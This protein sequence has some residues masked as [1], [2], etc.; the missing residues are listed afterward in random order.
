[1][2]TAAFAETIQYNS[3]VSEVGAASP[4]GQGE[5]DRGRER[6]ILR[7][8]RCKSRSHEVEAG[9]VMSG[10]DIPPNGVQTSKGTLLP[11]QMPSAKA[12]LGMNKTAAIQAAKLCQSATNMSRTPT[13]APVNA[14]SKPPAVQ[15]AGSW[16]VRARSEENSSAVVA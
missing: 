12:K 1:V 14:V 3:G 9:K 6:E 10:P 8:G 5:K 4:V 13:P 15:S 16:R 7:T 2:W 11:L